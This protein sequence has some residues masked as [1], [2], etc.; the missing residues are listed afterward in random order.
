M[1]NFEEELNN[2]KEA[3]Q[4]LETMLQNLINSTKS[5]EDEKNDQDTNS[6]PGLF[7][8]FGER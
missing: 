1:K 3:Q 6:A 5:K 7:V 4:R 2:L 8:E